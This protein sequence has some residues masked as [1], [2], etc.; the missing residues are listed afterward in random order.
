MS[1]FLMTVLLAVA[2]VFPGP[3]AALA[4][5]D[6]VPSGKWVVD[7]ADQDCLMA[8]EFGTANDRTIV[9][10]RKI[11][12]YTGADFFIPIQALNGP[13]APAP[14]SCSLAPTRRRTT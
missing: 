9:G 11:P 2:A 6:R 13:T 1:R 3:S 12:I 14:R 7:F 4:A 5:A 8:R 10:L